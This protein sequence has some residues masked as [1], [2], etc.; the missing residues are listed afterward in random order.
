MVQHSCSPSDQATGLPIDVNPAFRNN[1]SYDGAG[2]R[3]REGEEEVNGSTFLF[4]IR[5]P[6]FLLTLIL[7]SG[8]TIS[9]MGWGGGGRRVNC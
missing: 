7:L 5:Q 8:I 9:V 2:R 3:G 4:S 6:A 1:Y